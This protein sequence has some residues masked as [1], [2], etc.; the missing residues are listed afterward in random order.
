MSSKASSKYG[1][2]SFRIARSWFG[3]IPTEERRGRCLLIL[4]INVQRRGVA[5]SDKSS[6]VCPLRG[7]VTEKR[8][9]T[10][11]DVLLPFGRQRGLWAGVVLSLNFLS[12][13]SI[14]SRARDFCVAQSRI[15][16]LK[17]VQSIGSIRH[18]SLFKARISEIE[19]P[20]FTILVAMLWVIVRK[21]K[22]ARIL[23]SSKMSRRFRRLEKWE[24]AQWWDNEWEDSN[25]SK[26][27]S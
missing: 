10:C 13:S 12:V 9:Y 25:W 27:R 23:A 19:Q 3:R 14:N 11:D 5:P 16:F 1:V 6:A 20:A 8:L 18:D 22:F 26:I 21:E 24:E 17:T 7:G 4:E 15:S 2:E